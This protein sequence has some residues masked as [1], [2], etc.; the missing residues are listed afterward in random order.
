MNSAATANPVLTAM[1]EKY[2]RLKSGFVASRLAPYFH[3]SEQS[4]KY[5][6]F[7]RDN[8]MSIPTDLSRAPSGPYKRTSLKLSDDSYST[9]DKGI[10]IPVDDYERSKYKNTFTIDDAAMR[11][12]ETIIRVNHE[13]RVAAL[14]VSAGVTSSVPTVKWDTFATST[15]VADIDTAKEYVY[16]NCGMD[17][18]LMIL[19]RPVYMFLKE[20]PAIIDKIKYS[21]KGISTV[22]IMQEVFGIAEILVAGLGENTAASGQAVV[23]GYIWADNVIICHAENTEDLQAPNFLR[24]FLWTESTG[25]NDVLVESYRENAIKSDIH[26]ASQYTDEKLVGAELG[27]ALKDTLAAI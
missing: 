23:P 25:N 20:H 15:P 12:A 21:Q 13:K 27:Y 4:A 26:R 14:A 10:E 16:K 2:L 11:R 5:Y 7:D 17:A 3:A 18:N 6:V 24:T 1:L 22:E 9:T 19:P 8:M